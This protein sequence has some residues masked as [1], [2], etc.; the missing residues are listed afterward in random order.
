MNKEYEV[1]YH[2]LEENHW[3]FLGRRHMV[4]ALVC[5]LNPDQDCRILETGC[6]GGPL[7]KQLQADGYR[8]VTGIDISADAIELCRQRGLTETHVMDAQNPTFN[9]GSFDLIIASDVMEHLTDAPKALREWHRLLRPG[10][11]LMV[12]VPAFRVL[13]SPHDEVNHHFKR[14]R[15]SELKLLM[16][17]SGFGLERSLYWNFLLFFP[18]ALVRLI[19]RWPRQS[20]PV[21]AHGDLQKQIRLI[22]WLL[23]ALL[24]F[25][26]R[27][28]LA[29]IN[30]PWGVSVM[31]LGKKPESAASQPCSPM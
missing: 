26:N 2:L 14:Y 6:S 5:R 24:R 31:A 19:K 23:F 16:A 7:L 28:I 13:W 30:W 12:F 25:E 29:G 10:G 17:H 9:P 21:A 3:W 11:R 20:L 15:R 27:L 22:N 1:Q 18:V 4:H 8:H